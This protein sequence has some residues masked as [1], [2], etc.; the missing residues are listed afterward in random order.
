MLWIIF[1]VAKIYTQLAEEIDD[2]K[3]CWI[4]SNFYLDFIVF[5]LI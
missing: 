1:L 5:V 4:V 3:V 2:G